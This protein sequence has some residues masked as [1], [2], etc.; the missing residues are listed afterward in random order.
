MYASIRRLS[1]IVALPMAAVACTDADPLEPGPLPVGAHYEI[2]GGDE[3]TAT[4]GAELP[5]PVVVR[6]LSAD[7]A[8]V[9]G[10]IINFVVT[11][12]GGSVFAGRAIT[13]AAGMARERWT[14]GDAPGANRLEARAV[15][16]T[17]GERLVFAM[18]HA[19]GADPLKSVPAPAITL[20]ASGTKVKGNQ[21]VDLHWSGTT[22]AHLDLYQDGVRRA[23]VPNTGSYR[24]D[25]HRKGGGSYTYRACEAATTTCS[26]EVRVSF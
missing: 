18:F 22:A 1:V 24:D 5:E 19:T 15:D 26:Q 20:A 17:N 3:Q 11:E 6:V 16:S 4:P 7:G 25:L 9:A 10:Q 14:L 21:V 8:P 23:T 13:D 12:G 2:A